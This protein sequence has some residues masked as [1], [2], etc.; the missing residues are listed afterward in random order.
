M[1]ISLNLL[2]P[3]KK[4][5]LRQGFIIAFAQSMTLYVFIIVLVLT[6][7]IISVRMMMNNNFEALNQPVSE[8]DQYPASSN[9]IKQLNFYL[10]RVDSY[11]T[12]FTAWS[13]VLKSVLSAVPKDVHVQ[14]LSFATDGGVRLTGEA[15]TRDDLLALKNALSTLPFLSDISS[16]LSNLLQKKNV[17][18]EL[19]MRYSPAKTGGKK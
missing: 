10:Q 3:E 7:T 11:A 2:P 15:A 4:R 6:G 8:A 13:E 5:N 1:R 17:L 16:P 19:T 14:K 9:E 12:R 18:F